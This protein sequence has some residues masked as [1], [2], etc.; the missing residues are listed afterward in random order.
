VGHFQ[1][2][3]HFKIT[4]QEAMATTACGLKRGSCM[5][6]QSHLTLADAA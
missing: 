2:L 3:G 5:H 4:H 6:V 1:I